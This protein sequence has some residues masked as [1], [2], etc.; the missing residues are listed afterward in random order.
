MREEFAIIKL[1]EHVK[2]PDN[3]SNIFSLRIILDA[4][5]AVICSRSTCS[6]LCNAA[7]MI[8]GKATEGLEIMRLAR[9]LDKQNI[10]IHQEYL[11]CIGERSG[12]RQALCNVRISLPSS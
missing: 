12:R 1:P 9:G 3:D 2:L 11:D 6:P 10:T 5:L 8:L 7:G 4:S